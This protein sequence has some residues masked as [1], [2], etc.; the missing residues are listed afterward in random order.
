ML[1]WYRYDF[2]ARTNTFFVRMP[3]QRH[4]V[5]IDRV[6]NAVRTWLRQIGEQ[7]DKAANFAQQVGAQRS[8]P[9]QL[10]DENSNTLSTRYP[11]AH[12]KHECAKWSGVVI[13][14]AYSQKKKHLGKLAD[15]YLMDSDG[16]IQVVV[17][18]DIE[19]GTEGRSAALSVWRTNLATK[20]DGDE[21]ATVQV[22]EDKVYNNVGPL[23]SFLLLIS[24]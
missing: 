1:T 11:D 23:F 18:L 3:S 24:F 10:P 2:D 14:V 17:G 19:Y 21:L 12:F 16:N 9:I 6:E 4:E 20:E 22:V 13:E 7:E 5:F 15:D 8:S